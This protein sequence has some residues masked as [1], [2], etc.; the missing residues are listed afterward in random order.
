LE[1][2]EFQTVLTNPGDAVVFPKAYPHMIYTGKGPNFMI[3]F[4]DEQYTPF[5]VFR[6][7]IAAVSNVKMLPWLWSNLAAKYWAGVEITKAHRF[8]G[9]KNFCKESG[10]AQEVSSFGHGH[11]K[12]GSLLIH[13]MTKDVD[14][15]CHF[16]NAHDIKQLHAAVDAQS[17]LDEDLDMAILSQIMEFNADLKRQS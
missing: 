5:S 17:H 7:A 2:V 8:I 13:E 12:E 6:D 1:K 16:N 11:P 10:V 3:N 4:R 15:R 9:S 14:F